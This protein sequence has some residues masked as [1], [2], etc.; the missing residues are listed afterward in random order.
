MTLFS[1][2]MFISYSLAAGE[3]SQTEE[4]RKLGQRIKAILLFFCKSTH[5]HETHK[6]KINRM[7]LN[8][9]YEKV[10]AQCMAQTWLICLF[11]IW[12]MLMDYVKGYNILNL[13]ERNERNER[14]IVWVHNVQEN[15]WHL[16][17]TFPAFFVRSLIHVSGEGRDWSE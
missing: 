16:P 11:S 1:F 2:W 14:R 17:Y 8:V 5:T 9:S 4:K 6:T 10:T 13:N 7:R 15:M 3:R 12:I